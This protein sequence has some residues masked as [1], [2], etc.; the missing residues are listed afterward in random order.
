MPGFFLAEP[1]FIAGKGRE[2]VR[3]RIDAGMVS[4]L[5]QAMECELLV[6][7]WRVAVQAGG[8]VPENRG[9]GYLDETPPPRAGHICLPF[10]EHRKKE[11]PHE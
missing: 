4:T 5:V 9:R 2:N 3:A 11:L 6:L 10:D 7:P 8:A 1:G